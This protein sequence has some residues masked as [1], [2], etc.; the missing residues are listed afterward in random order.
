MRLALGSDACE[1]CDGK[2]GALIFG[3]IL[4]VIAVLAFFLTINF[5][6]RK[7]NLKYLFSCPDI[8]RFLS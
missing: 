2:N 8:F 1:I 5:E 7:A 3:M 4:L 6:N